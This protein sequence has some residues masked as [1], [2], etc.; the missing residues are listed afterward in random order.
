MSDT[1]VYSVPTNSPPAIIANGRYPWDLIELDY[2]AG[3]LPIQG[4]CHKYGVSRE[5]LASVAKSKNWTRL[6]LNADDIFGPG[7]NPVPPGAEPISK[8]EVRAVQ[9]IQINSVVTSHRSM[10]AK[11]RGQVEE[12]LDRVGAAL[13]GMP[14]TGTGADG[15]PVELPYKGAKESPAD[16]IDKL[17]KSMVRLVQLERQTYGLEVLPEEPD[18]SK[19]QGGVTLDAVL[20]R[21]DNAAK[22]KRKS[23]ENS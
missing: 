12:L 9:R 14:K 2:R 10:I 4:I 18:D 13:V 1:P 3:F 16:L 11:A 5:R 19:G 22:A 6:E 8:E 20:E 7:I 21:L 23:T 15:V 17:T